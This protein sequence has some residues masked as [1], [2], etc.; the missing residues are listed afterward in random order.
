MVSAPPPPGVRG[1]RRPW[2]RGGDGH[3][4][5]GGYQT[6]CRAQVAVAC[7]GGRVARPVAVAGLEQRARALQPTVAAGVARVAGAHG[8]R[9]GAGGEGARAVAAADAGAHRR[10]RCTCSAYTGVVVSTVWANSVA[11]RPCV[12]PR[13]SLTLRQEL[14]QCSH[15]RIR[16]WCAIVCHPPACCCAGGM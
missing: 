12:P 2:G 6:Q 5:G 7:R 3:W 16:D 1:N 8:R 14:G 13:L 10:T 11:M 4:A 15:M 9:D